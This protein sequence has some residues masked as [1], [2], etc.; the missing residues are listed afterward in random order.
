MY[1]PISEKN[2]GDS[3]FAA[4]F[5]EKSE[6]FLK[7]INSTRQGPLLI[8]EDIISANNTYLNLQVTDTSYAELKKR[9]DLVVSNMFMTTEDINDGSE[10]LIK[11]GIPF[12]LVSDDTRL[13]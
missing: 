7:A 11:S 4:D 13:A 5:F 12:I 2:I 9:N 1:M 6:E 3:E 10:V 8:T